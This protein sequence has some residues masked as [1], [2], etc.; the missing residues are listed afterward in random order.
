MTDHV[1]TSI[2][3]PIDAG[4]VARSDVI[5]WVPPVKMGHWESKTEMTVASGMSLH[6]LWGTLG[7]VRPGLHEP[8]HGIALPLD[9]L[10]AVA[11]LRTPPGSLLGTNVFIL[12][13]GCYDVAVE[14][15]RCLLRAFTR[16]PVYIVT[17]LLD[18]FE[19]HDIA[20]PFGL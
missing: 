17:A 1:I 9:G 18:L 20:L 8:P 11:T 19:V 13:S 6:P 2:S 5:R 3:G 7:F 12:C 4:A 14:A 15:D 10:P 16:L